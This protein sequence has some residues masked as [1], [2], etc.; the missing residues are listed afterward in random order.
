M[1][2]GLA[3]AIKNSNDEWELVQF[4]NCT[5]IG[6]RQYKLSKLLRGQLG[7]NYAMEDP[8]ASGSTIVVLNNDLSALNISSGLAL[9]ENT[10]VYGPSRYSYTNDAYSNV[11]HAGTKAALKP[12]SPC[13]LSIDRQADETYIITWVRRTRF[14]G[15]DWSQEEVPLHEETEQY[16]VQI[17]E[18][19]VLLSE[20]TVTG[21][22]YLEYDWSTYVTSEPANLT[23]IVSQYGS[24]YGG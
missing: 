4:V 15:D 23:I 5:L 7:T 19:V 1:S 16:S 14:D 6:T 12:Y 11:T 13:N 17:Y 21:Q 8:V 24:E 3:V 18:G 2:S 9:I 10:Y 20:H 22:S